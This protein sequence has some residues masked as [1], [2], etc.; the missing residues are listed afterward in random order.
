MTAEILQ[1]SDQHI[2]AGGA[3]CTVL[4]VP[5]RQQLSLSQDYKQ[6]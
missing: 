6:A 4:P 1:I 5:L 2:K 3:I